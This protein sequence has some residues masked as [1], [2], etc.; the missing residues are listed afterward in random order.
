MW[1][2]QEMWWKRNNVALELRNLS[3]IQLVKI[4]YCAVA[5]VT[6]LTFTESH[7]INF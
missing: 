5:K 7:T 3:S 4:F 6:T 1:R 2:P